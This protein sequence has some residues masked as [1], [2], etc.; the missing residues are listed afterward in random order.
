MTTEARKRLSD[1]LFRLAIPVCLLILIIG[2]SNEGWRLAW[3]VSMGLAV[4]A[5]WI[6]P[7]KNE[8]N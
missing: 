8:E 5:W 6:A 3:P 7:A 1:W 4:L 2:W